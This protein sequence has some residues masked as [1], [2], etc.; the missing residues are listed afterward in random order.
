[1]EVLVGE[2][3]MCFVSLVLE[4]SS[5]FGSKKPCAGHDVGEERVPM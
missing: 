3:K 2:L 5:S 1:M 4:L